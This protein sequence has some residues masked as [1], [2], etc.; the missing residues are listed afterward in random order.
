MP[1]R[2][3]PMELEY[4]TPVDISQHITIQNAPVKSHLKDLVFNYM[5][6]DISCEDK[7]CSICLE[8]VLDCKRCFTV[9]AC[10]HFYHAYCWAQVKNNQC[11]ECRQ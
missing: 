11:P 5:K 7:T 10:G 9:L 4:Y 1:R 2:Q 8:N 3:L 6:N